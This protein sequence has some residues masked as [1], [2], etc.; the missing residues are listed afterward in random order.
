[1]SYGR[2]PYVWKRVRGL[3]R[4]LDDETYGY[5]NRGDQWLDQRYQGG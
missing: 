4:T 1:M 5:R 3:T 2:H